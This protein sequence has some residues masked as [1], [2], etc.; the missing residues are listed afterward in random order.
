[1]HKIVGISGHDQV[2]I[3]GLRAGDLHIVF[4]VVTW[5]TTGQTQNDIIHWKYFQGGEDTVNGGKCG[6]NIPET[7]GNVENICD[8]RRRHIDN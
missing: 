3:G 8:G 6:I 7:S 2:K 4:K 1:M 5:Q